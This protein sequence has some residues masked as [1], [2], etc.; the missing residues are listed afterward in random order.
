MKN[1]IVILGLVCIFAFTSNAQSKDS[2]SN[3]KSS[4]TKV[5]KCKQND[6]TKKC[7]NKVETTIKTSMIDGKETVEKEV[8]VTK[9]KM[10]GTENCMDKSSCCKMK[11]ENKVEKELEKK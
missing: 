7:C 11:K 5:E 9:T 4:V 10:D 1:L 3:D 6:Q 8:V 2:C